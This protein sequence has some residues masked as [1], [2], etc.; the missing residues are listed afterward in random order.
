MTIAEIMLTW[1]VGVNCGIV[2]AVIL[3]ARAL[4]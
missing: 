2:L 4:P 1:W 3:W